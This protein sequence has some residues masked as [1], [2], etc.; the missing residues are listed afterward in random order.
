MSWCVREYCEI[1]RDKKY[2]MARQKKIIGGMCRC[3]HA[4]R[5]CQVGEFCSMDCGGPEVLD[6]MEVA[7][8]DLRDAVFGKPKEEE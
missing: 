4:K 2:C 6:K 8:V 1:Y 7:L 5:R 3:R